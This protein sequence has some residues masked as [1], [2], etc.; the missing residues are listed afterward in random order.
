MHPLS[1]S[2]AS[3]AAEL[4]GFTRNDGLAQRYPLIWT[5]SITKK[6]QAGS[7]RFEVA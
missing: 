3:R 4:L 5:R 2:P 1:L 6:A 7:L